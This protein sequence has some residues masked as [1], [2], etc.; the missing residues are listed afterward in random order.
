MKFNYVPA[1]GFGKAKKFEIEKANQLITPGPGSYK[2]IKL[3]KKEPM[4]KIGTSKR[5][6]TETFIEPG[7]GSYN[8]RNKFPNGPSYSI[9]TKP[10]NLK[11][12]IITPGPADYTPIKSL[13]K[14]SYSFGHKYK[15]KLEEITP[16]PGNY[17]LRTEKDLIVPSSIIGHEKR[18]NFSNS[19]KSPGPANYKYDL[20]STNIHHPIY[21]FGKEKKLLTENNVNPGPGSYKYK[22]YIGKE[23]KKIS[24]GLKTKS[25]SMECI[26][27]PGQYKISN[28]DNILRKLPDIKIGMEKRFSTPYLFTDNP[29]PGEY[30]DEEKIKNVKLKKPSWKIG[31]SS[32]KPLIEI[33]ESPGPGK[34]N[35]SKNIGDGSPHY[36]IK[37]KYN[38]PMKRF[39]TPGPGRYNSGKLTT[40]R[41]NPSWKIG[42]SKRNNNLERQIAEG[43]PGPGA[44]KYYNYHLLTSPKYGFGTQK[45]YKDISNDYPGPGSYHIPCS[46]VEIND[47]T[48]RQGNFDRNFKFI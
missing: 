15:Q 22:E 16:G 18:A 26:P 23:G 21:S 38:K 45:K 43:F 42:T 44:Y 31:T 13:K 29:G 35:I 27:G 28:Y 30:N 17:N 33:T 46:I 14:S 47:Y 37:N 25:K 11:K 41:K 5:M 34:Y 3:L 24:I 6:K 20:S 40:F 36:S 48:R 19:P 10:S 39:I 12:E 9:A 32:R 7:P 4:W 8:L 1:Y 2:P